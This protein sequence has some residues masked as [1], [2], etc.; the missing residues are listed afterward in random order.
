MLLLLFLE[1]PYN[2]QTN[3]EMKSNT[4]EYLN[5]NE[6]FYRFQKNI[7][8][9]NLI[10]CMHLILNVFIISNCSCNLTYLLVL[11]PETNFF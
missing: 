6:Q 7:N 1:W 5:N 11:N 10:F 2:V 8:N 4:V 9:L 3:V